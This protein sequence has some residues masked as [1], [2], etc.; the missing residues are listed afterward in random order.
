MPRLVITL[1][2]FLLI[3]AAQAAD[4]RIA[5]FNTES[6]DDTQPAKVAET[7]GKLPNVD[8]WALQEVEGEDALKLYLAAAKG[9]SP[10]S[11]R[12]VISESGVNTDRQSDRLGIL[13][14]IDIFRQLETVE[15]HAIR[16]RSDGSKYGKPDWRL[17]AAL[18]LRLIHIPSKQ[19]F[20]VGT[21]HLKCCEEG[22]AQRTHQ[23]GLLAQWI[24]KQDVPVILLGDTNIPIE[25]GTTAAGV[26][27]PAFRKLV[28]DGGLIWVEPSNPIKTQCDDTFN[29]M[30]D[31][32]YHTA[33]LPVTAVT[34]EIQFPLPSYCKQ[35]VLG[36]S[37]HRPIVAT[38]TFP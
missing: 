29:S 33:T 18:L 3:G 14:R 2:S 20:Y 27:F 23:A 31:Q 28:D 38:F 32:V 21:V 4:I 26:T 34:A 25:P 11:W 22:D 17:R 19:E 9:T 35:D 16:S 5:T 13:Y 37:D 7:I 12:S 24:R 8:I 1:L 6:D 36:F 10:A 15:F 30:L